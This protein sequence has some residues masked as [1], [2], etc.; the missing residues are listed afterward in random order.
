MHV[1]VQE[2]LFY[3]DCQF[4]NQ[5][6]MSFAHMQVLK[7]SAQADE[8]AWPATPQCFLTPNSLLCSLDNLHKPCWP[9]AFVLL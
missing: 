9:R 1:A 3:F 4:R 8:H 2:H 6:S 7:E 5:A